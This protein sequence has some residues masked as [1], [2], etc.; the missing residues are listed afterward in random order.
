MTWAEP[1]RAAMSAFES[2]RPSPAN[3]AALPPIRFAGIVGCVGFAALTIAYAMSA[4]FSSGSRL[5]EFVV[6][7][8]GI[9][10]AGEPVNGIGPWLAVGPVALE[11]AMNPVRLVMHATLDGDF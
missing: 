4:T 8:Q 1:R 6:R 9:D 10:R 11:P 7:D 2:L 3:R 5:A